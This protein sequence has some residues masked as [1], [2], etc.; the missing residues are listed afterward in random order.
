MMAEDGPKSVLFVFAGHSPEKLTLDENISLTGSS[1]AV[2]LLVPRRR[3]EPGVRNQ[4]L[5]PKTGDSGAVN[6]L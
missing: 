1:R 4:D 6:F 2:L 3:A 5:G